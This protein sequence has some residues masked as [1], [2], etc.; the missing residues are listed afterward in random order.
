[1]S[2]QGRHRVASFLK[3]VYPSLLLLPATYA[4]APSPESHINTEGT[5]KEPAA[6]HKSPL[7]GPWRPGCQ[8]KNRGPTAALQTQLLHNENT[9]GVFCI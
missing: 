5:L 1:M 8:K 6:P 2:S 7:R 4:S 9:A 3:S